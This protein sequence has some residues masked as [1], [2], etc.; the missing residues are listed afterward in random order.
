MQKCNI[1]F[2]ICTGSEQSHT[3]EGMCGARKPPLLTVFIMSRE[4]CNEKTRLRIALQNKQK[5][6]K[7]ATQTWII[8][9]LQN[10]TAAAVAESEDLPPKWFPTRPGEII[11]RKSDICRILFAT[12]KNH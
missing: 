7:N 9:T 6:Q 11:K 12:Q 4:S 3:T 5:Q 1:C 10:E 2:K 8:Q